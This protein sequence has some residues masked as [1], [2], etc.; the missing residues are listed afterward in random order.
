LGDF[1]MPKMEK[2]L[3]EAD[4]VDMIAEEKNGSISFTERGE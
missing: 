4:A 2:G 1:G 3:A